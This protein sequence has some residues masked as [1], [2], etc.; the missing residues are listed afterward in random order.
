M[1]LE[2]PDDDSTKQWVI[3][4]LK[5]K[6]KNLAALNA[7]WQ[8]SLPTWLAAVRPGPK[9]QQAA[10]AKDLE[11]LY[12]PYAREFFR[13]SKEA[14]EQVLPG[15][16]FLGC[17]CHRGP[18]VLGRAAVGFADV[19]SVNVYDS[20]VRSWQVPEDTDIPVISSEFHFGAVDRGVP[21]PGLSAVW[22]QNQRGLAYARYLASALAH[23]QF[24]GVHWFEWIDQSAAGRQDRENHAV[25]FVDVTGR[26]YHPFVDIVSDVNGRNEQVRASAPTS[27]ES[28]LEKLIAPAGRTAKRPADTQTV[29]VAKQHNAKGTGPRKPNLVVIMA[30]DLGYADVGFNGC[31]DIPTPHIDS[32]ATGGVRFTSGYV[33]YPVCGPSRAAFITGRYG[34]RFGFERNPLYKTDD[35]KMGLP[36]S[37]TT[38]ADSLSA[39]GYRCGVVGKWHLG[40]HETLHPLA[41]GFHDFFGHLGGGHR[42]FP[43]A[44]TIRESS[45]AKDE[46][47]SYQTWILQNHTPVQPRQY[48]TDEFSEAAV[49]FINEHAGQPFFLFL[50]YNAPHLPLEATEQ[51]LQ[52]FPQLTGKRKTYAAMVS[53]VDDGVGDVLAALRQADIDD[54]TLVFFLSDNGGP[55]LKNASQNTPLKGGKSDVWEGGYRVPFA[56]RYP[57]AIPAGTTFDQ[58]VSSLDIFATIAALTDA[59]LAADR[60]L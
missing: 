14:I 54:D 42:Y 49:R 15:T 43:E 33:A 41:R 2:L 45:D 36:R 56:A 58:P 39:V 28:A 7:A 31:T 35:P 24:V 55:H 47:Q 9:H 32:I 12:L 25:G 11:P 37:E 5:Q 6:Y 26:S 50:A 4:Q 46:G 40:A 60:P 38:I 34:Q 23:P 21:S 48:L 57:R 22:D 18:N 3:E 44:L 13:K 19:F 59:P 30:D 53:A 51:Y 17:R 52:R 27:I 20:Q 8:T 10:A 1:V 16:L 29:A